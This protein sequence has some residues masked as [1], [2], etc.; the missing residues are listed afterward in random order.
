MSNFSGKGII[1]ILSDI[2]D[3]RYLLF[4]GPLGRIVEWSNCTEL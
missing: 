4:L 3:I 1:P 2:S